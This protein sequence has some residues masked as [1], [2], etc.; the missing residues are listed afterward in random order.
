MATDTDTLTRTERLIAWAALAIVL[1]MLN[2][3]AWLLTSKHQVVVIERQNDTLQVTAV[4]YMAGDDYLLGL[5]AMM[6]RLTGLEPPAILQGTNA[7]IDLRSAGELSGTHEGILVNATDQDIWYTPIVYGDEGS[8]PRNAPTEPA[9]LQP[10]SAMRFLTKTH[11]E[12]QFGCK[13]KPGE[14][15]TFSYSGGEGPKTA[16]LGWI[17]PTAPDACGTTQQGARTQA[18]KPEQSVEPATSEAMAPCSRGL[19]CMPD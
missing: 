7:T 9:R 14:K 19:Y 11:G 3:C 15:E 8:L 1:T 10:D 17:T 16:I 13:D 12:Y 6:M 18:D 5:P 4:Y 2:G